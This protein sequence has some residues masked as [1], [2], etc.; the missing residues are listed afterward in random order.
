MIYGNRWMHL[1]KNLGKILWIGVCRLSFVHEL[2]ISAQMAFLMRFE[3]NLLHF[4]LPI[5]LHLFGVRYP[6]YPR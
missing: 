1:R 5:T 3:T 2:K 4:N 6:V